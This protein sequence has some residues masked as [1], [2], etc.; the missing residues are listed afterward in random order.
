MKQHLGVGYEDSGQE[1]KSAIASLAPLA[2][3]GVMSLIAL[4][5]TAMALRDAPREHLIPDAP[6][7]KWHYQVTDFDSSGTPTSIDYATIAFESAGRVE[8]EDAIRGP[9]I[10]DAFGQTTS[11]VYETDGGLFELVDPRRPELL[12]PIPIAVWKKWS[13][14][15][16]VARL[17]ADT[18]LIRFNDRQYRVAEVFEKAGQNEAVYRWAYGLGLYEY[19][20]R[21][22]RHFKDTPV[23]IRRYT[24]LSIEQVDQP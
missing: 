4:T 21:R 19:E 11:T 2:A 1:V 10:M 22:P 14:R 24:L 17:V 5:S 3:V 18:Y 12:C 7:L 13:P 20:V 9:M 6:T 23:I 15:P 16:G 8:L